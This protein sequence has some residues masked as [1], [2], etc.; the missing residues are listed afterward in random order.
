MAAS[1]E[2][3]RSCV[4]W[5]WRCHKSFSESVS[6]NCV[7]FYCSLIIQMNALS[8]WYLGKREW[9]S[10]D[11]WCGL[12]QTPAESC[13]TASPLRASLMQ[14]I[15]IH[16]R[17]NRLICNQTLRTAV[18]AFFFCVANHRNKTFWSS[19]FQ[20]PSL[21]FQGFFLDSSGWTTWLQHTFRPL[22]PFN[23]SLAPSPLSWDFSTSSFHIPF[24]D[25]VHI[26]SILLPLRFHPSPAFSSQFL[27][28]TFS[29]LASLLS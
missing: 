23:M 20:S 29:S 15:H 28:L 3:W 25:Y 19:L 26:L 6:A 24:S 11:K 9:Q 10:T 7:R 27:P 13:I 16:L 12:N 18:P 21:F 2:C 8:C 22:T 5:N 17:K 14:I 1:S 4:C